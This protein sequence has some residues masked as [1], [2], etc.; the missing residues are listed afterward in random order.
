METIIG[1]VIAGSIIAGIVA[2]APAVKIGL[3]MA[4]YLYANTR[5]SARAGLIL[6]KKDYDQLISSNSLNELYSNLEDSYY[7]KLI[8]NVK[9]GKEISKELEMDLFENY[10]WLI[11]IAPNNLKPLFEA[12]VLKFEIADLKSAMNSCVKGENPKVQFIQDESFRIRIESS[13][14]LDSFVAALKDSKFEKIGTQYIEISYLSNQLDLFYYNNV[15]NTIRL[16][17]DSAGAEVFRNYWRKMIDLVNMRLVL[18]K[19]KGI[20]NITFIEGGYINVKEF[21][22]VTER[23]Q[24]ESLLSKTMYKDFIHGNSDIDI[25]SGMFAALRKESS[26]VNAKHTLKA[27][28]L[29]RFLIEKEIEV[30]N[31]N[32]IL[33]LK[34][35]SFPSE[36]I[37]KMIV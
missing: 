2:I 6:K 34:E 5:C 32:I 8:E 22:A 4:P 13:N 23:V 19:V 28:S 27:G 30:R 11:S 35:E 25:E 7:S 17:K 18:R 12:F 26:L 37:E 16:L 31:L 9:S 14:D 33:K 24:I 21:Q 20:E 3:D 1:A 15:Y 29:V 36:E 10:N